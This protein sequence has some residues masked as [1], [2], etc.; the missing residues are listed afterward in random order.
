MLQ[1][2]GA[3]RLYRERRG[4]LVMVC[5]TLVDQRGGGRN[6]CRLHAPRQDG[7]LVV[8]YGRHQH[9]SGDQLALVT[10]LERASIQQLHEVKGAHL[11][12]VQQHQPQ[13]C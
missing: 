10:L 1:H 6:R 12:G 2:E 11:H 7:D 9:E 5:E 8:L 3:L 13:A 4:T